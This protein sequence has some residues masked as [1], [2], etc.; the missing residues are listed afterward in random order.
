LILPEQ[1]EQSKHSEVK[2]INKGMK[3]S[4]IPLWSGGYVSVYMLFQF[5]KIDLLLVERKDL[6]EIFRINPTPYK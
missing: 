5:K 6:D 3:I 1:S 2:G 4:P